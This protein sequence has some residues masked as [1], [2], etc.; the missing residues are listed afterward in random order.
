LIIIGILGNKG[1]SSVGEIIERI[2]KRNKR[3]ACIIGTHQDSYAEFMKLLYQDIEYAIIEISREDLLNNNLGK[4]KFDCIIQTSMEEESNE[5]V[6]HIQNVI[7]NIR[8]KGYII[9]N[10]DSIEKINFQYENIYPITY[11]LNGRTTVTA[12]SIDDLPGL[13]FSYCLQRAIV[14]FG[15]SLIQPFETPVLVEGKHD[16]VYYYLAAYTCILILGYKI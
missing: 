8:E 12:S 6:E 16:D 10:S 15:D 14:T 9:F 11:G 1:K 7:G 2:L 5:L 4:I 13:S 3:S